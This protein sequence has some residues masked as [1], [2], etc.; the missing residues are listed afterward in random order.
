MAGLEKVS[1]GR[2][3]IIVNPNLKLLLAILL[4]FPSIIIAQENEKDDQANELADKLFEGF[5]TEFRAE[6]AAFREADVAILLE[7][8]SE[9]FKLDKTKTKKLRILCKS[10]VA[11]HA[12]EYSEAELSQPL[13]AIS[14][15]VAP[16]TTFKINGRTVVANNEK[17]EKPFA[18]IKVAQQSQFVLLTIR[19]GLVK[20]STLLSAK[21]FDPMADPNWLKVIAPLTE[22][23]LDRFKDHLGK[24]RKAMVVQVLLSTITVELRLS[25]E[26]IPV[27]RKWIESSIPVLPANNLENL[28]LSCAKK[29]PDKPPEQLS[30]IQKKNW[31]ALKA[32]LS[33]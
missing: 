30:E 9:F 31:A 5:V 33:K 28:V 27:V 16:G 12:R 4:L 21:K 13:R 22:Q 25:K 17:E 14:Q 23:D 8:Q 11:K 10:L 20:S 3:E 6:I 15:H 29:L 24:E 1:A 2:E 7:R 32:K 18:E 19:G 26:Q